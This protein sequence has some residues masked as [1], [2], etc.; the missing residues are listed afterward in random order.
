MQSILGSGGAIGRD[1]AKYLSEKGI[2]V[3]LVARNPKV[4]SAD[5]ELMALDLTSQG[6][7]Y[8]A[9]AGSEVVYVT[10]GFP[11]FYK[12]WQALWPP[13]IRNVI[14]ACEK[15]D[16]KLVFFDN[17]Y[18]YDPAYLGN[19]TES[20]PLGPVSKKG[21]VR[22]ELVQMIEEAVEKGRIKALIARSADFYGPGIEKNSMMT[23]LI[24]NNLS[25]G[26][27]ANWPGPV[28]YKHSF[29]YT[30]DAAIA[31]GMLGN[32]PE[33]FDQTWHLPT[34]GDPPTAKEWIDMAAEMLNARP[35]VQLLTPFMAGLL[36]VFVPVLREVKE[37]MYQYEQD[38]VFNS[39][40]FNKAFSFNPTPYTTGLEKV[41][42]TDFPH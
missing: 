35:R 13:F 8:Q 42:D 27:K 32:T 18:M 7:V 9:V 14:D 24:L 17:I 30:P 34:A 28:H 41:I 5:D 25:K 4:F 29:T 15:C 36:G 33:A 11:Y 19:M 23:E 2:P 31:T 40:K 6:A 20:T 3:R 22:A 38:Y 39:D 21:Q 16:S 1:L 12:K 10:I 26:K 37:M